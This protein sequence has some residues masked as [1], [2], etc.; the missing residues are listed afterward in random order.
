MKEAAKYMR[1]GRLVDPDAKNND[2]EASYSKDFVEEVDKAAGGVSWSSDYINEIFMHFYLRVL[3]IASLFKANNSERVVLKRYKGEW[4]SAVVAA[5]KE[6]LY[7]GLLDLA[8]FYILGTLLYAVSFFAVVL[9][10]FV[11]PGLALLT[12]KRRLAE[13]APEFS[14]V[15]SPAAFDKMR[16]LSDSG[17]V[18]FY[19]DDLLQK[20]PAVASLYGFG[21]VS[22]RILS[23]LIVPILTFRDYFRVAN[24]SRKLL[25]WAGGGFALYYFSKRIAHKCTFEYYLDLLIKRSGL[26]TYYTGN[27][28]DRFAILE[29]RLCRKYE[30]RCVCVPHGIEYAFKT[31][32]GL[33]GDV[34]YCTTEHARQHLSNLYAGAQ[35]F[36]YDK[37]V[38]QQM[39]SRHQVVAPVKGIVFFPESRGADVNLSI[40]GDLLGLGYD[41][42]VK[43]HPKDD[44]ANYKHYAE[45]IT[46][47]SDFDSSISNKICL[48]RKSTVLVEAI[49]NNSTP[50]AILTD[51]RDRGYVE[52]M[53]PSLSDDQI[54]RVY[55][56]E[57]L[58]SVLAKLQASA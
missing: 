24:D 21:T 12:R 4:S 53:L 6:G 37:D 30:V 9:S 44:V 34:F 49:Y 29:K 40:L 55:S 51:P 8:C 33:V 17:K 20:Q 47:V 45:Q 58:A 39:F 14:V 11:L 28:E 16:F 19:Y 27:K 42:A 25:G 22:E 18:D 32:A 2:L 43:L 1:S 41:I 36:V 23:L 31:P 52:H 38:A 5:K 7:V 54:M 26:D 57:E 3:E 35:V 48:A 13:V 56:V 46:F 15:R 50:I 10:A